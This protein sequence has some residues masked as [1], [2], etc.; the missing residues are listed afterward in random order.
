MIPLL[1]ATALLTPNELFARSRAA[2]GTRAP[3]V[4]RQGYRL[5]TQD[6][7]ITYERIS[8]G[9][10]F[11]ETEH[12]GPFTTAQGYDD[13]VT[14]NENANGIVESRRGASIVTDPYA[15]A[16]DAPPELNESRIV[17]APSGEIELEITPRTGLLEH[18]FY[19]AATYLVQRID[20]DDPDGHRSIVYASYARHFGRMSASHV[21]FTGATEQDARSEDLVSYE[22][23]TNVSPDAFAAP[24]SRSIFDTGGR[25]SVRIPADVTGGGILVRLNVAG[26]GLD[27]ILDSGAAASAINDE[28]ARQLG[29]TITNV[30]SIYAF[31][32]TTAGRVMVDDLTLGDLHVPHFAMAAVPFTEQV[33]STRRVVGLLGADFF[34]SGRVAIDMA[35]GTVTLYAP[36]APLPVEGYTK[37]P[38]EVTMNVP[39]VAA[40][41]EGND[42]DVAGTFVV[43]TGASR[44]L[45]YP[46][47]FAK[48]TPDKTA[49]VAGEMEGVAEHPFDYHVYTFP[50]LDVGDLTFPNI[51]TVVTDN[52]QDTENA[53]FDGLLGWPFLENFAVIFDYPDR[54][55]YLKRI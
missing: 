36:D 52:Q 6:G 38:I 45:L 3:G 27:F 50:R 8:D 43:D 49:G 17:P 41:F 5:Q 13:G 44:T 25:P 51:V 34:A 48:F 11:V 15:A 18:V 2:Y 14:W 35:K 16:L 29:L 32:R 40:S 37:I 21:G 33:T 26:R 54:A 28:V 10:N 39:V 53:E 47:Y 9:D 4:Y 1:A 42:G 7:V 22:R 19:D 12:D 30:H 46:H 20:I 24:Q 55:L 31:G 23:V